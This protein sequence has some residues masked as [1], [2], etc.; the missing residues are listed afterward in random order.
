MPI[1]V[2]CDI[3]WKTEG[4]GEKFSQFVLAKPSSSP[5]D[6]IATIVIC[7]RC[8]K[9]KEHL[10]ISIPNPHYDEKLAEAIKKAEMESQ[11]DSKEV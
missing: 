10:Y 11:N 3:C 8:F 9:V 2:T 7:D 1:H 6:W 5:K 4:K